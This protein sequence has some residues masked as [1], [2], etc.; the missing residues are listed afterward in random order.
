MPSCRPYNLS[1]MH[2]P[3]VR[4]LIAGFAI[5]E[6]VTTASCRSS[7]PQNL[8][9]AEAAGLTFDEAESYESRLRKIVEKTIAIEMRNKQETAAK[10]QRARPYYFRAYS[11]YPAGEDGYTVETFETDSVIR[12]M[13]GSAE[14]RKVRYSTRLHRSRDAAR[15]DNDLRRTP[16]V[17]TVSYEVRNGEWVRLGSTFVGDAT[18]QQIEGRWEPAPADPEPLPEPKR[19]RR[20][21]FG[22]LWGRIVGN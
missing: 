20:G 4:C 11:E 10:V 9:A 22:R 21:F 19:E 12:P 5:A 8:P 13:R 7:S 17:E 15:D 14:V 2:S 1:I 18:E 16:G 3:V 6:A